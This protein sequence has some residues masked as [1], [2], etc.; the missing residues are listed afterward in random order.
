M[1]STHGK[2]STRKITH[3][4]AEV[5]AEALL[6]FASRDDMAEALLTRLLAPASGAKSRIEGQLKALYRDDHYFDWRS[7][8]VLAS[9]LHMM[10]NDISSSIQNP[11][12][13]VDLVLRFYE[14]DAAVF[15]RCDA[16][17]GYIGD[18]Y[19]NEAPELFRRYAKELTDKEGPLARLRVLIASDG[20]GVRDNLLDCAHEW[21]SEPEMRSFAADNL[22]CALADSD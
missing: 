15:E 4:G 17:D 2:R 21:L 10:L 22:A 6:E 19:R 20:Y 8:D 1:I 7:V 5:L 16:S 13:G 3:L 9:K 18:I 11:E 12:V 14:A